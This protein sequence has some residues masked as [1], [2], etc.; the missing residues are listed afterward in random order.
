MSSAQAAV[1][2]GT[3]PRAIAT[4]TSS[5]TNRAVAEATTI[6]QRLLSAIQTMPQKANMLTYSTATATTASATTASTT[7]AASSSVDNNSHSTHEVL[8][9]ECIGTANETSDICSEFKLLRLKGCVVGVCTAVH[10]LAPTNQARSAAVTNGFAS[11]LSAALAV[12]MCN[13]AVRS[14]S[15]KC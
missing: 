13:A 4:T 15:A 5:M 6:E 1:S 11:T 14:N 9:K 2:T 8:K 10:G 3:L 12:G 7:A